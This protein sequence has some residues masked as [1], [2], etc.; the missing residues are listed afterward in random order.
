MPSLRGWTA[1]RS[2]ACVRGCSIGTPAF[3]R[4]SSKAGCFVRSW[5]DKP[6]GWFRAFRRE[7][8]GS[9]QV[10]GLELP[11]HAKLTRSGRIRSAVTMAF[12][13]KYT[14]PGSRKWVEGFAEAARELTT[15]EFVP[16]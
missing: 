8:D 1:R 13:R 10:E 3:G 11:V 12:A 7:P 6:A 14:T 5:N 15:L 16:R 9:V 4:W 2:L